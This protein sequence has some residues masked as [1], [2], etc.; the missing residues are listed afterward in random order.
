ML[1]KR[2]DPNLSVNYEMCKKCGGICCKSSPC[3]YLPSDFD[4]LEGIEDEIE[5]NYAIIDKGELGGE[6]FYYLRI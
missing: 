1:A 4:C 5:T 3:Q 6:E 2:K